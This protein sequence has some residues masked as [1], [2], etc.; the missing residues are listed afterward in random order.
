M[1]LLLLALLVGLVA[2]TSYAGTM[3]YRTTTDRTV[4]SVPD[5][6]GTPQVV[7]RAAE[8]PAGNFWSMTRHNHAGSNGQALLLTQPDLALVYRAAS[9]SVVARPVTALGSGQP[10]K[11]AASGPPALAQD[12]SSFSFRAGDQATGRSTVWRLN[13]TV[14]EALAPGYVPPTTFDDPRLQLVLEDYSNGDPNLQESFSHTWSPDGTRMAYT[15]NWRAA[16]GTYYI[17]VRVKTVVPGDT[18]TATDVRLFDQP[19]GGTPAW[20]R[21]L[22]WSPVSDQILNCDNAGDV[23]AFYADSPGVRTWV[24]SRLKNVSKSQ[25]TTE[26]LWGPVWRPDGQKIGVSYTKTVQSKLGMTVERYPAVISPSGWPA[27]VLQRST[28]GLVDTMVLG[29][30]P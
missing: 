16:D 9:G 7:I 26:E 20:Y 17:S 25:T 22:Q 24:A 21:M 29:W 11:L 30:V 19:S 28:T 27:T 14:D 12:D 3:Y 8:L 6:G 18:A 23:M 5:T 15:D 1:R 13:V 10:L 2:D 4:Y